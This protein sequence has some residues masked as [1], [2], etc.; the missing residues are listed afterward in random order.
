MVQVTRHD[1]IDELVRRQII[2]LFREFLSDPD[3][4]L[5][6]KSETSKRLK[7]SILSKKRGKTKSLDKVLDK[8]L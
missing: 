7:K 3:F 2:T 1:Q 6:L 8:Y 4:N 5:E